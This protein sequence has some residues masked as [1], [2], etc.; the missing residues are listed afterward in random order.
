[1]TVDL[2][3]ETAVLAQAYVSKENRD[4]IVSVLEPSDFLDT[5]HRRVMWLLRRCHMRGVEPK[6][7]TMLVFDQENPLSKG[8]GDLDQKLLSSLEKFTALPTKN[9]EEHCRRV[10]E[11][12]VRHKLATT[13]LPGLQSQVEEGYTSLSDVATALR[14][15][16]TLIST[17]IGAS[18]LNL[19]PMSDWMRQYEEFVGKRERGEGFYTCGFR[20]IDDI[21]VEGLA[22]G[23]LSVWSGRSSMGKSSFVQNMSLRLSYYKVPVAMF[24]LEMPSYSLIDR[25]VAIRT[26]VEI[27]RMT[28]KDA[29]P[30]LGKNERKSIEW[31]RKRLSSLPYLHMDDT[32]AVKLD[33]IR[34][35][36]RRLQAKLGQQYVVVIVDLFGKIRD[37]RA[38]YMAASYED[39]LNR[40]QE[41]ARDL[42]IH[43]AL[44]AQI[45]R[46]K[47]V[48]NIWAHRPVLNHI[49]NSGA[50]EEVADLVVLFFRG[51]YYDPRLVDDILEVHIAKQRMG[52]KDDRVNF[53]FQGARGRIMETDLRPYDQRV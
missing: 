10:K 13:T 47:D 11:D 28:K 53:L 50:W 1:V 7:E 46:E 37:I 32:P 3:N 25:F 52:A 20:T 38:D 44:V 18:E 40:A 51:K 36:T 5:M 23:K 17:G 49:K 42:G 31:E 15:A 22:P 2:T 35:Q 29:E 27:M 39:C 24:S 4:L 33:Y 8:S 34:D 30:P 12:G 43:L 9:V 48:K 14:E 21:L 16:E 6:R 26:G 41:L 45:R 19:L